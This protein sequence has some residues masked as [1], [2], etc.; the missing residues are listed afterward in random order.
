MKYVLTLLTLIFLP[1]QAQ[2]AEPAFTAPDVVFLESSPHIELKNG[3]VYYLVNSTVIERLRIQGQPVKYNIFDFDNGILIQNF[4]ND[5]NCG[6]IVTA[7]TALPAGRA[8]EVRRIGCQIFADEKRL[9]KRGDE[10][11]YYNEKFCTVPVETR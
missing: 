5:D 2:A 4:D 8:D 6:N 7:F 9:V 10:L 11:D 1:L 3:R